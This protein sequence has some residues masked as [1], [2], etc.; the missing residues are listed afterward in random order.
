MNVAEALFTRRTKV[1][2]FKVQGVL[3]HQR[4]R[5]SELETTAAICYSEK[6]QRPHVALY[7]KDNRP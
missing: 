2:G 1:S 3:D 4:S 6:H 7:R 5:G